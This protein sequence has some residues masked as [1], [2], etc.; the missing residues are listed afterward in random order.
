MDYLI[1]QDESSNPVA[2]HCLVHSGCEVVDK[3]IAT[4]ASLLSEVNQ[5]TIEGT[6]KLFPSLLLYGEDG[7]IT[8]NENGKG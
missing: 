7:K 6:E 3:C 5:L 1:Y 4:L 8:R 2:I